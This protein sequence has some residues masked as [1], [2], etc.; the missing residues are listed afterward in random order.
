MG[1][2]SRWLSCETSWDFELFVFGAVA[3]FLSIRGV[4]SSTVPAI[5]KVP[6]AAAIVT[7][8]IPDYPGFRMK[9]EARRAGY[10]PGF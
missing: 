3:V 2:Q 8:G 4:A 7:P 10:E 9:N 1:C 6:A 5:V